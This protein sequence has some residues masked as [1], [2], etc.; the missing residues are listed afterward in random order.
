MVG[1]ASSRVYPLFDLAQELKIAPWRMG[2]PGR[3][4]GSETLP[5]GGVDSCRARQPSLQISTARRTVPWGPFT[6]RVERC[7]SFPTARSRNASRVPRPQSW[8]LRESMPYIGCGFARHLP[9]LASKSQLTTRSSLPSVITAFQRNY[10]L[11]IHL[12]GHTTRCT[13]TWLS[14]PMAHSRVFRL[15]HWC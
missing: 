8:I 5:V 3:R 10:F 1:R 11:P 15:E 6:N 12:S 13:R 9:V 14:K 4:S 2:H 7:R